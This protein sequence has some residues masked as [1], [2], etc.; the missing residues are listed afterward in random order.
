M[1][2]GLGERDGRPQCFPPPGMLSPCIMQA[3]PEAKRISMRKWTMQ[4]TMGS[5]LRT[6]LF[7]Q[8]RT[9]VLSAQILKIL[10][11]GQGLHMEACGCHLW[12]GDVPSGLPLEGVAAQAFVAGV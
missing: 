8:D 12:T 4:R 5:V 7:I 3:M 6:V 10:S 11:A 9:G 2:P 1:A